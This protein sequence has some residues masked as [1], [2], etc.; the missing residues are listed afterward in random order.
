VYQTAISTIQEYMDTWLFEPGSNW[1]EYE[2]N[3]RCYSRWAADELIC[4]IADEA[5]KPPL[6][7]S[8]KARKTPVLIINEFINEMDDYSEICNDKR[9]QLIFCTARDAAIDIILLFL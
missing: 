3:I 1:P 7:I 4:R 9:S 2:F 8:G 5:A 6:H